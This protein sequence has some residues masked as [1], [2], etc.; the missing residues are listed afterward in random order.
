MYSQI[1]QCRICGNRELVPILNLGAQALT[2]VFPKKKDEPVSRAPLELVKCMG[3]NEE[4]CGLVQLRH[5]CNLNE[6]YAD[7]YGYRSGLN[8]SMVEHLQRKVKKIEGL[9]TL[10]PG[11]LIVDIGS[12]DSTLLRSY[13]DNKLLLVGIDP[14]GAKFKEFYP[15]YISLIPSF[16]SA[17]AVKKAYPGKKA[18]IIT[19]IAMFYDLESP[20]G[21]MLEINEV[22][23]D[24]GIWVF[25]QSYLPSML[26]ANAYDTVCHEHLEYYA[27]KQIFWLTQKAGLKIIEVEKN[28]VNGGS[29]SVAVAKKGSAK[30]QE[31]A[32]ARKIL[33]EEE[34]NGLDSLKPF[35]EFS[36]RVFRH[37]EELLE[38]IEKIN[39]QGKKL[40]GY[41]A[42][43][44]GNVILQF[45]S[46]TEK[47]IP[48][49][50]EVN[51]DKFGCYTPGTLIPIISEAEAKKM[52]PDFFLVLPWHFRENIISRERD[53]LQGGGKLFFPLPQIKIV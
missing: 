29:F 41:G 47:E 31:S 34:K 45:C 16:F 4:A 22:L 30:W 50:A 49:I 9:V 21:F 43:T 35:E 53:Y 20:L 14:T 36:Q 48:C 28:D 40:F 15:P 24:E 42:S 39:R 33:K 12:N 2:G 44:K 27:L 52:Q 10:A 11:D 18:K 38:N 5:S 32:E 25:E 17:E 37:R 46:L 8:K 7:N 13:S 1:K 19:S 3:G 51:K 6:L 23:G 26:S